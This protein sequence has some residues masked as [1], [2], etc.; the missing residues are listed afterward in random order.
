MKNM[1]K[2]LPGKG[3]RAWYWKIVSRNGRTLAHSEIYNSK[4]S[5]IKTAVQVAMNP[6]D[7]VIPPLERRGPKKKGAL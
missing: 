1:I 5:A 2:V 6:L 4:Q 3:P 7:I